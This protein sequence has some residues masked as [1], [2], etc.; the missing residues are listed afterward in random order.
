ML[1]KKEKQMKK[2]AAVVIGLVIAISASSAFA[3][4]PKVPSAA[5]VKGAAADKAAEAKKAAADKANAEKDKAAK[6][7]TDKANAAASDAAAKAKAK[8]PKF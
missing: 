3:Q 1:V 4:L 2:L 8:V 6:A 7:A 5:D